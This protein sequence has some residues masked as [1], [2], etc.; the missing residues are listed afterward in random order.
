VFDP[1]KLAAAAGDE[2]P[3]PQIIE[4]L[5]SIDLSLDDFEDLA[6][7]TMNNLIQSFTFDFPAGKTGF[8]AQYNGFTR[9][10]VAQGYVAFFNLQFLGSRAWDLEPNR[11]VVRDVITSDSDDTALFNGAFDIY[12]S[13]MAHR[14]N[15]IM[16]VLTMVSTV[17]L[18]NWLILSFFSTGFHN[19]VPNIYTQSGFVVMVAGM[20]VVTVAVLY[21]FRRQQWI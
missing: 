6:D 19:V 21:A 1:P 8:V 5:I 14:T 17:L 2:Y 12:V 3:R 10:S 13:H 7:S 18:P 16:K 9:K 20:I 15:S 11:Q 4:I